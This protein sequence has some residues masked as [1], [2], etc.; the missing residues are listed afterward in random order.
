V[1]I[2]DPSNVRS[3]VILDLKFC[4][5]VPRKYRPRIAGQFV[6]KLRCLHIPGALGTLKLAAAA[7]QQ[8]SAEASHFGR[9]NHPTHARHLLPRRCQP[10]L[11]KNRA[12]R[13]RTSWND[14]A[15]NCDAW[16]C[17]ERCSSPAPRRASRTNPP[18]YPMHR[19]REGAVAARP[20]GAGTNNLRLPTA[21]GGD[22]GSHRRPAPIP[23]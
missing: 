20:A 12:G 16:P 17:I 3:S 14:A 4:I 10:S 6:A 21:V 2:A 19:A 9:Q 1:P 7:S 5:G 8:R 15:V 13:S 11:S 18:L 23:F 22:N